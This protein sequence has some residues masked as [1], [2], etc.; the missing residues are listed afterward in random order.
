MTDR[1]SAPSARAI[2][3]SGVSEYAG[4][5]Y[6]P[7][8][9]EA[10]F[11]GAAR[12]RTILQMMDDPLIGSILFGIESLVRRVEWNV[13]PADESDAAQQQAQFI[14][15]CLEDMDGYWPGDTLAQI[16]SFLGW[17]WSL[18][19][20]TYKR[21]TGLGTAA[22]DAANED[23]PAGDA[24]PASRYDDGRIGWAA[25]G[26]RPQETRWS[27][28]FDGDHATAFV[29]LDPM[30][31]TRHII[32]L[33]KCLLFRIGGRDNSPESTTPLRIAFDAWYYKRQIQKIEAIGIERDLAG[34]PLMYI[35]GAEIAA[36]S[37]VYQTAQQIVTGLRNDSQSGVVLSGDRDPKNG[38]RYFELTLLSS[39]GA[40]SFD[41][42][43]VI[44]RYANEVV[45][46]FLA[47]VMR[48][49]Q[50]GVGTFALAETQSGLFQQAIG[51]HLDTIAQTIT[52]QAIL[53][54]I[55]LNGMDDSLAP[56]LKHGD[57]ESADLARLGTYIEQ[58]A[59]AGLLVDTPELKAF[60]HEV[61]GLPV[62]AVE[63][64]EQMDADAK[65]QQEKDQA[66]GRI[67]PPL[68]ETKPG[69]EPDMMDG[70]E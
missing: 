17:G 32:P 39:G 70:G 69:P 58:L 18:F 10:A 21:R 46:T 13:Q 8:E 48:A 60:L 45:T 47:N 62:P 15:Q 67:N 11:K 14:E 29:Q 20:L 23:A 44:R 53:P 59:A 12:T 42:D 4:I 26:F 63:E 16:L 65:A 34:L 50:D 1:Q 55:R 49:G 56:T 7:F 51:A 2:G 57:I 5:V 54:L 38:E 9:W 25:W 30:S 68:P 31:F 33:S 64:L 6:H 66:A 35:P 24:P 22:T 41:T 28:E 61:A 43:Q 19:E 27:W 36:N 37:A 40:H 52:E 3:T